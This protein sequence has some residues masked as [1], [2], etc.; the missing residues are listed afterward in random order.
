MGRIRLTDDDVQA[1][2]RHERLLDAL[3]W[4]RE[5]V[6]DFCGRI[7]IS[8]RPLYRWVRTGDE[9]RPRRTRA[10]LINTEFFAKHLGV[11]PDLL[12]V[13]GPWLWIDPPESAR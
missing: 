8:A 11:D 5:G 10:G 2:E 4:R 12:T 6:H 3:R 7:G 13:G 9:S 1:K